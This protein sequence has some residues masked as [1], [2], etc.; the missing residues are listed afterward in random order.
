MPPGKRPEQDW[1]L[2]RI[3]HMHA[4]V[5]WC[6]VQLQQQKKERVRAQDL[7]PCIVSG[8]KSL[9]PTLRQHRKNHSTCLLVLTARNRGHRGLARC[10]VMHM[11]SQNKTKLLGKSEQK[12]IFLDKVTYPAQAVKILYLFTRKY[13]GPN[14][15]LCV[16]ARI[17]KLDM[18]AF[19]KT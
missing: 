1:R 16:C 12:K 6:T 14:S 18:T 2:L 5:K 3:N 13:P 15:T 7:A 4:R 8:P 19:P 9:R 11:L 17:D 10:H